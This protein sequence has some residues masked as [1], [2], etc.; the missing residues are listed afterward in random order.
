MDDRE[1]S[2]TIAR[3]DREEAVRRAEIEAL[4]DEVQRQMDDLR[5]EILHM[6]TE[7]QQTPGR[8]DT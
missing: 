4:F 3:L 6:G 1:W 2:E 7:P 8:G 5:Q